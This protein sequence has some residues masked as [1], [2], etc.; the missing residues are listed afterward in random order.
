M[1]PDTQR[2]ISKIKAEI[3]EVL[4]DDLPNAI[5][6]I[7]FKNIEGFTKELLNQV[8]SFLHILILC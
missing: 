3:L 6:K 1:E 5:K 4:N 2:I 8:T 7:K